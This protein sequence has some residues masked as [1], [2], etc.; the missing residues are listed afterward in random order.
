MNFYENDQ[1]IKKIA[2][3]D[4]QL[5]TQNYFEVIQFTEKCDTILQQPFERFELQ[6]RMVCCNNQLSDLT[7]AV[8]DR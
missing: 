1:G 6:A 3:A 7:S 8:F 2:T 5:I 4:L